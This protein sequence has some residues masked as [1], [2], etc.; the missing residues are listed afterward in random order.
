MNTKDTEGN[1]VGS[2][3]HEAR[4]QFVPEAILN[5][6]PRRSYTKAFFQHH[7]DCTCAVCLAMD[8][9]FMDFYS[10]IK[11]EPL[12]VQA[13]CIRALVILNPQVMCDRFFIDWIRKNKAE[14]IAMQEKGRERA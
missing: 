8:S 10:G 11:D 12:E 13:D 14:L 7:R 9:Q 5:A 6:K 4:K 2:A 3:W 1:P